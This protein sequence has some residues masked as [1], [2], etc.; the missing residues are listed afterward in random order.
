M[1][2][3]RDERT[4]LQ[5]EIGDLM[6]MRAKLSSESPLRYSAICPFSL[7]SCRPDGFPP[8][9]WSVAPVFHSAHETAKNHRWPNLIACFFRVTLIGH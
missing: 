5:Q 4:K 7:P 3:L 6:A 1:N 2:K 8:E 9:L